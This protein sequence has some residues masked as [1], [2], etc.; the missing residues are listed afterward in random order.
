MIRYSGW[1]RAGRSGDGIPVG[2][3]FFAPVQ[4]GNGAH[5]ASYIMGTGYFPGVKSG[6]A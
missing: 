1:I 3:E 2:A 6:G 4:T 5:P